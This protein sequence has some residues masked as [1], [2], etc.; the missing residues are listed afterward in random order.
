MLARLKR[1]PVRLSPMHASLAAACALVFVLLG[2]FAAEALI[3]AQRVRQLRELNEL[4]LRRA[5]LVVDYGQTNLD[6]IVM[7]VRGDCQPSSLQLLRLQVYQRS[8]L[9]DVRVIDR[10]GRVLCSAYSETLEFDQRWVDRNEMLPTTDGGALLFRVD[11]LGGIALGIAK[12]FDRISLAAIISLNST[13]FDLMPRDLRD[14]SATILRLGNGM[15]VAGDRQGLAQTMLVNPLALTVP[16]KSFSNPVVLIQDS[17]RYPFR[18]EMKI[19]AAAL[20]SW[21]S[22]PYWPIVALAALLGLA[23]GALLAGAVLRPASLVTALDQALASGAIKPF[24]L[25]TFELG[26]GRIIG[27]EV[28]ARWIKPD[29]TIVPPLSFI[30][31]AE[32]TGRIEQLTWCVLE[33]ALRELQPVVGR[34]RGFMLSINVMPRHMMSDGFVDRVREVAITHRVSPRQIALEITERNSFADLGKAAAVVAELRDRG[35][36]VALDDVGI[37]H[38][39]LSQIQALG[40]N[41]LKIDKFFVDSICRYSAAHVTIEMLVRLARELKMTVLAEGIETDEQ[42]LAL[43]ACEVTEGQGYLV[44]PPLPAAK[45]VAL[46]D[47]RAGSAPRSD[48]TDVPVA[49]VA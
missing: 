6:E 27:C 22:E 32:N 4:A 29:G 42:R 35:F 47:E 37:G 39:G 13:I 18:V 41:I 44:S 8:N 34:D 40:A 36:S 19:E 20:Q 30:P 10:D 38:N 21:N 2:H 26:T 11:Q 49:Q 14:S 25:P 46:V 15:V 43:I 48:R 9:K 33:Q 5:E 12:D 1:F 16:E 24:F 45:F 23:F 28:L 17:Q 7:H 31:L 3:D